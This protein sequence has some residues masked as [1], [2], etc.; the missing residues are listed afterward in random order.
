MGNSQ[1]VPRSLKRREKQQL[2]SSWTPSHQ[3]DF[4]RD[5]SL[6]RMLHILETRVRSGLGQIRA[7]EAETEGLET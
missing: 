5:R 7:G 2:L 4:V 6:G 3:N 1:E